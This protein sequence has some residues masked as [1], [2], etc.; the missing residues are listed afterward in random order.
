MDLV[1]FI[2]ESVE[3]KRLLNEANEVE[4]TKE[5]LNYM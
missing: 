3:Q 1:Q 2:E 5:I 4:V